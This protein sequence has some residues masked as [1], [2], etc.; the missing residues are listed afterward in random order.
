ML[1]ENKILSINSISKHNS[2][3]KKTI[4]TSVQENLFSSKGRNLWPGIPKE[5]L[6]E[7]EG[8]INCFR[9]KQDKDQPE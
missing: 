3:G 8:G 6:R 2:V 5:G 9:T 7:G 1:N 4:S